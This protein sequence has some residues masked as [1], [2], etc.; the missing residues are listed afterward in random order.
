[1]NCPNCRAYGMKR[2]GE[3]KYECKKCGRI[4]VIRLVKK[5]ERKGF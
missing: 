1:M 4:Y 3:Y 5:A 2:L